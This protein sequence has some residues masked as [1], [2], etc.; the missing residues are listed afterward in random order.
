MVGKPTE[1]EAR[2]GE[3]RPGKRAVIITS[4]ARQEGRDYITGLVRPGDSLICADG[5][6][7]V[8]L[9][10]GLRPDLVVGDGDSLD[11]TTLERIRA[12]CPVRTFP[13]RKDE[14]DTHLA[15]LAA[16]EENPD[17]VVVCGA[18][19]DRPDH[20]LGLILL[21]AG[22]GP[23]PRVRLAGEK[24]EAVLAFGRPPREEAGRVILHG[25][26]G[27]TVSL[28]P[29]S[30]TVTGLRSEGLSYRLAGGALSWGETR[31]VSNEMTGTRASVT[32][33]SGTLVVFHLRGAW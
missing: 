19:G 18:F 13:A 5:G 28:L 21:V 29:L 2:V 4:A 12:V 30:P 31:G 20:G 16:L 10:L 7:A 8:A 25:Q 26:A 27:D 23:G 24:L 14:T 11:P 32:V 3:P 15:L 9:E 33:D 6:A 1:G 22:L 17:E